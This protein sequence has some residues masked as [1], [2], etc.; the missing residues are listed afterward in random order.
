[1]PTAER[2]SPPTDGALDVLAAIERHPHARAVL[3]PALP[4][5]GRPSHAY[6]FYGPAGTG[7]RAAARAF[8][9]ALLSDGA[10]DP[11][12]SAARVARGTHPDLTWVAPSGAAE[13][14][15]AD[16]DEPVVAAAALTPFE[17]AR[18]V[19]VIEAA[20]T[21]NDQAANRMLKTLEEPAAFVHLVLIT[22]RRSDVL[23]TIA[24]RCQQ[25][26]FDP[27]PAASIAAE[28][29]GVEP[30]RALAC[31][32]LAQGDAAV[33]ELLAG[34][35]GGAL[36]DVAERFI[37][38]TLAGETQGR[39]WIALL[40]AARAA[41]A[42]A[43]ERHQAKLEEQL[44]LLSARTRTGTLAK[45]GQASERKRYE[46]EAAEG[47]RRG[48]R[49]ARTQTLDRGLRLAELWLRDMLCICE[50]A[51]ELILAVDR[52]AELERDA[53][54]RDARGLAAGAG[55]VSDTRIS[56]DVNVSEE[57]ALE[58]LAYRLQD[59]LAR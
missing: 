59:T 37:R 49:R 10:A 47:R 40:D 36:R 28:L 38:E 54:G 19:F 22:D 27:L 9:A 51:P 8:A 58:A 23:A 11:R 18:R 29:A 56:L 32:R 48:E 44:E 14:L 42:E 2:S 43:G 57:L 6:L 34:A 24:S 35:H 5:A 26:R 33:A 1:M 46:R 50:G 39:A 13:M 15:V 21:M 41:G 12:A 52:T 7:K 45:Q 30:A 25:V 31:A 16:V 17:A 53:Q 20:D 4:P 3:T 55:L